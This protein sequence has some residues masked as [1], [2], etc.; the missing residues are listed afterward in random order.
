MDRSLSLVS[1]LQ[2]AFNSH[3]QI[4]RQSR[5]SSILQILS[6]MQA[7]LVLQVVQTRT[8]VG[9]RC[10]LLLAKHVEG[11]VLPAGSNSTISKCRTEML[12]KKQQN[13][14]CYSPPTSVLPSLKHGLYHTASL[15]CFY[16]RQHFRFDIFS[17]KKQNWAIKENELCQQK[18]SDLFCNFSI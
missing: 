9:R 7:H 14:V 2:V 15:K 5:D 4:Q 13:W 12:L 1:L 17:S 6:L 8:Y 3:E 18:T 11:W 10:P 16:R